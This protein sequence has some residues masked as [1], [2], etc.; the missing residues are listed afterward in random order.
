MATRLT[1]AA[2]FLLVALRLATGWHFYS[3]GSKKLE[4]GFSSAGFLRAA[5]G[6][7]EPLCKSFVVGPHGA[8]E[9]LGRPTGSA[10]EAPVAEGESPYQELIDRVDASWRDGLRRLGN[11][12]GDGD[13]LAAADTLRE[14]KLAVIA[15]YLDGEQDA[16]TDL[17]HE[18]WRLEQLRAKSGDAPF[19][20][21]L[22]RLKEAEVWTTMQPWA[23][24]IEKIEASYVDALGELPG[25]PSERRIR[26]AMAERSTLSWID[27]AVTMVVLGSGVLLFLGL[28]TPVAAVL[29]AGFLCSVIATQPP[30]VAGAD[31]T[32]FFYQVVEVFALLVLAATGAGRWAGLDGVYATMCARNQ[33]TAAPV[34]PED[35]PYPAATDV[36]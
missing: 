9:V 32:Y 3:E 15:A 34:T 19:Q 24:N 2:I 5:K 36:A 20:Q 11:V 8:F 21:D 6:P 30:W 28:W 17:R 13:F 23:R 31:T 1:T 25:A 26:S 16:I 22:V 10:V 18:A 12:G 27:F 35:N 14:E 29:A 7:L 33:P 4:P